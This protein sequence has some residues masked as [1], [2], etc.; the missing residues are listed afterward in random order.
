MVEL[1]LRHMDQVQQAFD[2][3]RESASSQ[4]AQYV[5]DYCQETSDYRGAIEFLLLA[6]KSDEAFKLAQSQS[7]VEAYCS[8][9]GDSISAEDAMKVAHYYEKSQKKGQAGRFYSL[10][11]QY[12]KALRLFIQCGD[13]EIDAAIEVVGKSQND[14]LTHQLIDFL[15]GEKDGIPKDQN[16]IY[17]LYLA[18]K[19]YDEAAKTALI[20]SRDEQDH[21]N[22]SLAHSVVV[23]TVRQLEAV[24]MKVPSQLR[25]SF[26]LLHSYIL[27]KSFV[28]R[29]DHEGAARL[30]LRI[31]Q[32]LS[33]FPMHA[34]QILTSTVVECQ[35]A[36]LKASSYEYAVMLMRPE[37]RPN[38]DANLKRKIEAIVRRRTTLGDS[39]VG[40]KMSPCPLS[41]Q[42]IPIM[43]LDCP[44]TRD[45]LPMCIV[46]GRHMVLD[47]WCFC[48]NSKLPALYSEYIRYIQDEV[49]ASS[50]TESP[51]ITS[52]R[53]ES[54]E[55]EGAKLSPVAANAISRSVSAADPVMGK[56]V[57]I[58]DL[59]VATPAEA[60]LYI[61]R[62]N[63]VIEK[64]KTEEQ[65]QM[66]SSSGGE[67]PGDDDDEAA[68]AGGKNG[69]TKAARTK[70][71]RTRR[72]KNKRSSN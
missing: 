65:K 3:V 54:K 41:G 32:N 11:G 39:E 23:E 45:A 43:Q 20:I 72:A 31:A 67:M 48:P 15:L 35:R 71:D 21:G 2:L 44:T 62:Y 60:L 50:T 10:C 1:K 16:Y 28:R 13:E 27:V 40:E 7:I 4:G 47:D 59:T 70:L 56:S 18:L 37:Y 68:A 8:F 53:H 42:E 34:V 69:I 6:N 9:L 30:L 52:S 46:T 25:L 29:G 64:K 5:A 55:K 63:N 14:N 38:I 19:K 61:Q 66:S 36:G 33:K 51:S 58:S 12:S 17:R 26:V 24:E 57:S 22:Y 49:A